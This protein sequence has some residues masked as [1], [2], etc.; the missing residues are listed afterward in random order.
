MT[1]LFVK[2][3]TQTLPL[4]LF[5]MCPLIVWGITPMVESWGTS[6]LNSLPDAMKIVMSVA[7]ALVFIAFFFGLARF[8]FSD[9]ETKKQEGRTIIFWSVAAMFVALALWG[10]IALLAGLLGVKSRDPN[11]FLK[12]IPV[13]KP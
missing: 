1:V 11:E 5:F 13:Q 12:N 10:I 4:F 6:V 8:L 2:K 7:F 9:A 3:L